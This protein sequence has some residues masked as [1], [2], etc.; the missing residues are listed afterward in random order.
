MGTGAAGDVAMGSIGN[1]QA[2]VNGSNEYIEGHM[3]FFAIWPYPD[4]PV[5][6]C[7]DLNAAEPRLRM[8]FS[9]K[10]KRFGIVY[11]FPSDNFGWEM[12]KYMGVCDHMAQLLIK[13][14]RRKGS[15]TLA[16]MKLAFL[17]PAGIG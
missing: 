11:S 14:S 2:K 10:L 17:L 13:N 15:V 8:H 6:L 3:T 9:A 16:Q 4:D 5:A 7:R 1:G 12:S